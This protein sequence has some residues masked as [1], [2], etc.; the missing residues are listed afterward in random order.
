MGVGVGLLG[1]LKEDKP[2]VAGRRKVTPRA[3]AK[4]GFWTG[5]GPHNTAHL[6][7]IV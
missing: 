7:G 6:T 3:W 2:G 5:R 1:R 4:E